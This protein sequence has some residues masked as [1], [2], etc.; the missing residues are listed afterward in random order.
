[1]RMKKLKIDN[2]N[3]I[4]NAN[5]YKAQILKR[6]KYIDKE[7]NYIQKIS[8]KYCVDSKELYGILVL[9]HLNRGGLII[10]FI[11]YFYIKIFYNFLPKDI[12]VGIGQIRIS[13]AKQYISELTKKEIANKLLNKENNI[14]IAAMVICDYYNNHQK[15]KKRKYKEMVK[16][17][18]TG[19]INTLDN[20]SIEMYTFLLEWIVN[21]EIM[22]E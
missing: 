21:N 19:T 17:Y 11:E 9:E 13:T 4:N 2:K 3:F 5:Y 18:T 22:G 1:M 16:F 10:K 6:K 20:Y 12:T 8:R 7:L 14:L 15:K